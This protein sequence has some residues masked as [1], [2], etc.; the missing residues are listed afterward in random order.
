MANYDFMET[1]IILRHIAQIIDKIHEKI[2]KLMF[3]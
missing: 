3:K 2:V 1:L